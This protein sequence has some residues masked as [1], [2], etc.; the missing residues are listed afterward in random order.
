MDNESLLTN[1][2]GVDVVDTQ[3][4]MDT[5]SVPVSLCVYIEYMYLWT[6]MCI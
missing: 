6:Y 1:G 4:K 2:K 5:D 3:K